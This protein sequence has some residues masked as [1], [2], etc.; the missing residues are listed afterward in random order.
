M[1]IVFLDSWALVALVNRRDEHHS[2]ALSIRNGINKCGQRLVCSDWVLAEFLATCARPPLR[3]IA[4]RT[5]TTLRASK[6]V[7]VLP[8]DRAM[9]DRAFQLYG[10]RRDKEWSLVDCSTIVICNDRDIRQV[11]SRD[12]H[13]KQAGLEILIET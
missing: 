1:P 4:I 3:E 7:E 12:D 6:H 8:A 13:F 10:E 9:W 11:F 2:E 5:V